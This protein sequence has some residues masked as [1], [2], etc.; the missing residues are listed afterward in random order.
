MSGTIIIAGLGPGDP[1]ALPVA[2]LDELSAGGVNWL[3]TGVHPVVPWLRDRGISFNTFDDIYRTM[4]DFDKVYRRIAESIIEAGRSGRVLYAVPGHPMVAEES[5][6][7]IMASAGEEGL[8]V[9][10]LPAMSFL[11]ALFVTLKIDPVEGLHVADG[12]RL[13]V[14][15]PDPG[16]GTVL[17]QVYNRMVASDI[18]LTLMEYYP[19]EHRVMVVR[20]AGVPGREK[21]EEVPLYEMDRL[22]WLDHLTCLYIPPLAGHTGPA[23]YPLDP[24]VDVMASLRSGEGCPWDR[25][26]DHHTLKKYLL[27]ESY[28]VLDA[29]E[30]GDMYNICEELGDLLLQIVFHS[31]IASE[32]GH[33]DVNDVVAAITEKM[34]RRHPHVFADVKVRNSKEVLVNWE[35]IKN[36]EKQVNGIPNKKSILSGIPGHLAALIKAQ[37]IQSRAAGV[38]FDWPDYKGALDKVYEELEEIK[39]AIYEGDSRQQEKEIGDALFAVVNLARL[40]GADAEVALAGTVGRFIERFRYIEEKVTEKGKD[41]K[42]CN[43]EELDEYWEEAKKYEKSTKL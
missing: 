29:I 17:T 1:A 37:K 24:L 6:R 42:R 26:Q 21:V 3:R 18:K 4:N 33:F 10:V 25:E 19:E 30:K 13:D 14:Q 38:G 39:K 7:L 9:R 15:R 8:P 11:D 41:I 23:R 16:A 27:E 43:L 35:A 2:V 40:L 31:R 28:E 12:L 22:S 5:V 36:Q 20:A 34:I 32:E